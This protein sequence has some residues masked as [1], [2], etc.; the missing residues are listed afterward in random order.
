MKIS[1]TTLTSRCLLFCILLGL[2]PSVFAAR[3]EK[4]ELIRADEI[5]SFNRNGITYRR[6]VGDVKMR[7]GD[8]L[9]SCDVAEFQMEKDEA[10]LSGNVSI[11]TPNSKLTSNTARYTGSTEYVELLG[12]ARFE[13]DPFIVT[14]QKLGYYIDL[15]K[16]LATD[17][18]ALQDS[19]SLLLADTIY[20]YED[21]KLGDARGSAS[22]VNMTDSLSVSG[23][24]LLYYSGKDSLLSYGDA[25][26]RK[27]STKDTVL[28]IDSDSLSL[29]EGYFFA[30]KNVELRNGDVLGTCGQAVYMQN[31]DVAIMRD[32]PRLEEKDFILTGD[33]FNLH[34]DAGDLKSV[35]VPEKPHFTQRKAGGDTTFTDWLDG[36]IMAVEFDDGQPHTVTLIEMATSFFNVIEDKVFKGSNTVSGDTLFILL[37]D[38]S[39][40]DITVTGG[41]EGE[42]KPARGSTDID[43]PIKYWAHEIDYSMQHE[44]TQLKQNASIHYGDMKLKAG[45]IGVYWRQN[46]LRARSLVDTLGA[47]DFPVLS[48]EGQED[49]NGRRMVYDLKTQRGKVAAGRTKMDDG[50][51]YG[52]ELTRINEDTYLMQDGY[53][54][55]CELED[56]PHFYFYSR[57]MKLFTDRIIIAKPV[58][59]YIA[60][61]PMMALPFAVFP[62]KK[63]RSSG[64]ILPS[65]DYRPSNGGRALKGFGYYWAIN[66]YSDFK[67]MGTFWD[68]YEEFNLRSVLRYKK[69]YRISGN[70]DASMVSD[71]NALDDPM[72]W[73]WR[74][75]FN[76]NHTIDPSFSI[77]AEGNISGDATFD[78]SYSHDQNQRL[79]TKLHSG[80]SVNKK[81]ESINSTVSLSGTYDENLQVTRRVE[82]APESA[83][84]KLAGPTLALPSFR[85]TRASSPIIKAKG[86]EEHW[87][88][89]FRWSYNNSFSNRRKW[90]YLSYDNPD[91]SSADSLLWQEDIDDNRTW[92]HNMSLSGNTQLLRVLKLVGSVSYKDAWGFKYLDPILDQNGLAYVDSGTGA[93]ETTEVEGFIRR[94]TFSTS[95]SLNTKLY[96]IFPVKVGPL[97]AIRHTMTP[98][99]SLSY[100]PDFSTDFWGY[101]ES[102]TDTT[103][104]VRQFDRFAGSDL[105]A[106]SSSEALRMSYRLNNVFD[107]KLFRNGEES[108]A[109]FFTWNLSGSYNFK[110]D[111]LKASDISSSMKVNIG[112]SFRLSP[113]MTYEIYER[114][115]TG[116]RK[117]DKFRSPRMTRAG[118]SFGFKLAGKGPGGLRTRPN[119]LY[120]DTTSADSVDDS[121]DIA[122]LAGGPLQT[123]RSSDVWSASFSFSYAYSHANPLDKAKQ[124]F[125]LGTNLKFNFS[126]NWAV[127]YNP[128][129]NL[130]EKRLV[131]G[132]I[133]VT[134]K[135]HCWKMTLSWTPMGRWGGLNLTIRPNAPQLQDLKVEHTSNRKY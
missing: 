24:H 107:Y 76:H 102:I 128:R 63:G 8:A 123:G 64:F 25:R 129:F 6:L 42:F 34:M 67:M 94:G 130:I 32:S 13:D 57:Q 114:D 111:S 104:S 110:A 48:Q 33:I 61:I 83:G 60:D 16:V 127:N 27:W 112:K 103:G 31:D 113:T 62:Q 53:Y 84:I 59:L 73:K 43:F 26:F 36:K 39:I 51:Y 35:Y 115:S 100:T 101:V 10:L 70:I 3:G 81:F 14:A 49:F 78:R 131:S 126:E 97:E 105:G 91:T 41:A 55:T 133:G 88:N 23:K 132:S 89:S 118:F 52:E 120:A 79:D 90:S 134:R 45:H 96:G 119:P 2:A 82:E 1:P 77:R 18:P 117:I 85:F 50:N 19:G 58:V 47:K 116:T 71:R 87:Y 69:R 44:T 9:L 109:Q 95:A 21:S 30:W 20:Y 86:N 11:V 124:T 12:D 135:L 122:D 29:E 54:T 22:M 37:S 38:S 75:K 7:R 98:S 40:S 66:D 92:N 99:V 93:I 121:F 56:H 17:E 46:L 72:N 125:N 15:K 4:L 80:I 5:Q 65:Y 106:T 108:K 68:Q 74:L 28:Q